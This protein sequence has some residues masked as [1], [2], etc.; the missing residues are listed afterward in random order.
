V[1]M[2]KISLF[3]GALI[4]WACLSKTVL[5]MQD[6]DLSALIFS[7]P[8]L[9]HFDTR[10]EP[11]FSHPELEFKYLTAAYDM[12]DRTNHFCM[13]GYEFAD[14]KRA[15]A[16]IWKEKQW[17][18]RWHGSNDPAVSNYNYRYARSLFFSRPIDMQTALVESPEE[19]GTSS[20]LTLRSKADATV[21][22]CEA[23][24]QH[25]VIEPFEPPV[26][27]EE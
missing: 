17:L 12:A 25:Y 5:A 7:P 18:I 27:E 4:A 19:I 3:A 13:V 16:V 20:Y 8:P 2:K 23:N 14:E 22:D 11:R 1:K 24:G 6:T 15:T 9:K 26:D 10:T 21:A